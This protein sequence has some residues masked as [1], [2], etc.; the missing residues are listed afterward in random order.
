[1]ISWQPHAGFTAKVIVQGP[2][3]EASI[4]FMSPSANDV[5]VAVRCID[6]EPQLREFVN[7]DTTTNNASGILGSG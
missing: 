4:L 7:E 6:A 3:A 2:S 1:L 5:T